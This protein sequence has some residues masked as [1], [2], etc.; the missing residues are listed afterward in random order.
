MNHTREMR[1]LDP[2]KRDQ[3]EAAAARSKTNP[4]PI[5]DLM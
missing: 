1:G 4:A 3:A 5:H 2:T